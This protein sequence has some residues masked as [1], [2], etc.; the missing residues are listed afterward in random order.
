MCIIYEKFENISQKLTFR[1]RRAVFAFRSKV[2]A[3]DR[4]NRCAGCSKRL[5]LVPQRG[6]A[7]S[8]AIG[9]E[10]SRAR[11]SGI[12]T[13]LV[14]DAAPAA[15]TRRRNLSRSCASRCARVEDARTGWESSITSS[16]SVMTS[17]I[18]LLAV[19]VDR[20]RHT[21]LKQ[22]LVILAT[23]S[24]ILMRG[25]SIPPSFS[26]AASLYTPAEHRIA[27]WR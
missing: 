13:P 10:S 25:Y 22:G 15:A 18:A 8:A 9:C 4:H 21:F 27:G 5:H 19:T 7:A 16:C 3:T 26:T 11:A 1:I 6:P 12:R 24:L 17:A 20:S 23:F 14:K 2:P